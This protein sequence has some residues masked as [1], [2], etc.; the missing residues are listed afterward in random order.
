MTHESLEHPCEVIL[1]APLASYQVLASRAQLKPLLKNRVKSLIQAEPPHFRFSM[2][3][4][5]KGFMQCGRTP[6]VSFFIS[7]IEQNETSNRATSLECETALVIPNP[8][9]ISGRWPA[10]CTLYADY[11]SAGGMLDIELGSSLRIGFSSPLMGSL[12][13]RL[14]GGMIPTSICNRRGG[15]LGPSLVFISNYII[16]S[17][18]ILTII[19]Y[20]YHSSFLVFCMF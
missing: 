3:L 4:K 2:I 6:V 5:W 18:I 14:R 8:F 9:R 7:L 20:V 13:R 11:R 19:D 1:L 16:Y 10:L 12:G 17:C 15:N